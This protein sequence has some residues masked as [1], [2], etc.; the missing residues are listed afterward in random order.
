MWKKEVVLGIIA[1]FIGASVIPCITGDVNKNNDSNE[2]HETLFFSE[3]LLKETENYVTIDITEANTYLTNPGTP[4]LPLYTK[5]YTFP[6]GTKIVAIEYIPLKI[7]QG[8]ILKK[9]Q[10]SPELIPLLESN[11]QDTSE[12][13]SGEQDVAL[14]FYNTTEFY[15]NSWYDYKSS[16]GLQ[17]A[18][19]VVFLTVT[20]YP[21]R[22]SPSTNTIRYVSQAEYTITYELPIA[23]VEF[24]DVYDLLIITPL[25]FY[26][27]LTEFANYK[28]SNNIR[29]KLVNLQEIPSTGIDVQESIKYYI[30][31]AVEKWN[32]RFVLLIGNAT[33]FP[34]RYSWIPSEDYETNFPSDLYYADLYK[35]NGEFAS[36]DFNKNKK[37]GEFLEDKTEIDLYPDVYLGR[38][39]CN[40]INEL[41]TIINKIYYYEESNVWNNTI[42]LCA[43]DTFVGD[44]EGIDEGE[45]LEQRIIENLTSVNFTR[46]WV[47]GGTPDTGDK[48]LSTQTIIDEINTNAFDIV[49]F[50]GHG[51]YDRW[52]THPHGV[53][54]EWI[55][56]FSSDISSLR[57]TDK[58]PISIFGG[59]F[60][61]KFTDDE[62]CLGWSFIN[63]QKGG[64]VAS[65]G[66]SG[67]SYGMWGRADL[68][69]F[70]FLI[71]HIT[72]KL[73]DQQSLGFCWGE[74]I[75]DF[76]N[77]TNSDIYTYNDFYSYKTVQE[78]ILFGD[79][80]LNRAESENYQPTKPSQPSGQTDGNAGE[81]YSYTTSATDPDGDQVYYL[82]DWGD[83]NTSGWL[84]PY[85]SGEECN[86]F[87]TWTSKGNYEI[88]VK[89]KD[90]YG[91]ESVWSD[92]LPISMPYSY[93]PLQQFFEWLFQRFHNA[94]PI[95]RKL[96]GYYES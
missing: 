81:K 16:C 92:P 31:D 77:F 83:G 3:P 7:N 14:P 72:L 28:N 36:W 2:L 1:L 63:T 30:K 11:E 8:S 20:F 90:I 76:L 47:P 33:K 29:T 21:V 27:Y 84:G 40:D 64:A 24:S 66:S 10:P 79:P 5:T 96:M 61:S 65:F 52:S 75:N 23:S 78:F 32:V 85:N 37:Y 56:F 70:D 55:H 67:I 51:L 94:F 95:L 38:L 41:T 88:K 18:T 4:T 57:N 86:T 93:T 69:F 43:G 68:D 17:N 26:S 91:K 48:P 87:H 82:W 42:L 39:P 6:F 71:F 80:T 54:D 58:L 15:P 19:H 50:K 74:T 12:I 34:V 45:Y 9:I 73:C 59:C 46:L 53:R 49:V 44:K 35:G 22:Y 89:T 62:N 60:C 25:E 13:P